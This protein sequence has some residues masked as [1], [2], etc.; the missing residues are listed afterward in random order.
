M[1]V[2]GP[3]GN[4]LFAAPSIRA[5]AGYS[6]DDVVGRPLD[7]FIHHDDVNSFNRD[8]RLSVATGLPLRHHYRLRKKDGR[9][10]IFEVVGHAHYGQGVTVPSADDCKCVFALARPYPSK[11]AEEVDS[12]LELKME[13]ELLRQDIERMRLEVAND[14]EARAALEQF[15]H[16][17]PAARE[18]AARLAHLLCAH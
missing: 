18:G 5:I 8:M 9:Y 16:T 11:Q 15:Q 14:E 13:N 3:E 17:L 12:F 6:P 10:V 7:A 1:H 2:M 4:I